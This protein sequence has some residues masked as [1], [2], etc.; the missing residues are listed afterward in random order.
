MS[1]EENRAIVRRCY[2]ELN[3]KNLGVVELFAAN[4]VNHQ[5][6]GVEIHGPEE[7][8]QFLTGLFTA[9]PDLRFTVED[10]I[11]EGDKVA[12]RWTSQ[13]THNGEFMGIAPAGKQVT[14]T[15]CDIAHWEGGK[16]VE[17]WVL[18]DML[19]LMQQLGVIPPLEQG[20]G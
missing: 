1:V 3:K 2:E 15:V 18:V 13:G 7:L 12:A 19:G 17:D 9:F 5:A 10:L 4:Y 16:I 20:G 8:K 6:G 14:V 11:A